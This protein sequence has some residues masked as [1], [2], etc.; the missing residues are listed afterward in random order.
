MRV[1]FDS[2]VLKSVADELRARLVGG[3]IQ[4]VA[5]PDATD[6]VLTVRHRAANHM[7]CLSCDPVFARA[8]LTSIKRPNAPTPPAF[9]M[10]CRKYME[11]GV[12]VAID[13]VDF[14]RI[15]QIRVDIPDGQNVLIAELMGKHSNL[16][17]VSDDRRV[18]DA[19]KRIG[20]KLSRHR[21]VVPGAVYVTP[22]PQIGKLDPFAVDFKALDPADIDMTGDSE[23]AAARLMSRFAGFSPFLAAEIVERARKTSLPEAWQSVFGAA[24]AGKW[25]PVVIRNEKGE[26]G[27]AYPFPSAQFPPDAQHPRDSINTA[28]DHY[29]G[30]AIPRAAADTAG[31]ELETALRRAIQHREK[32]R[33]SL[34]RSLQEAGRAEQY[35][36]TGELILANLQAIV[37]GANSI[38]VVD[39]FSPDMAPRVIELDPKK[40][41]G[42]NAESYFRRYRKSKDGAVYQREQLAV[43][44]EDL[45]ALS[46]TASRMAKSSGPDDIQRMRAELGRSGLLRASPAETEAAQSRKPSFDGKRIRIFNTPEGWD[47]YLGENSEANDFLT[48]RVA[49]PSDLWLHVRSS[50]SAHVVIR[51]KNNPASVPPSVIKRAAILAAQHSG[52]KHASIVPVDY[53]LKRYVRRPRGAPSGTVTY[54]HE[55][56][57][58][59]SPKGG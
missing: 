11:G 10:I 33:D 21:E 36:Q 13:Q 9:C 16:I 47:I 2:L 57:I 27:G 20:R 25:E 59:V 51:T 42:E 39:L 17:V 38:E 14:D 6:L 30:A 35:K 34:V 28:L 8:H 46:E 18:L 50:T 7:L 22:P 44:E 54:Q 12:V 29:Y 23:A 58:H 53:T 15:L 43:I 32:K 24:A 40:S 55:K 5:Q 4:H 26:A 48:S 31:H 41:A 49:A 3:R 1:P 37:P 56:T 45:R 19:A 52:A